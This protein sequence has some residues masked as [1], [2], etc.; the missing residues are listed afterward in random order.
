M[1]RGYFETIPLDIEEAA[2]IDGSSRIGNFTRIAFPL[3]KAGLVAVLIFTFIS[4]WQDFVLAR[5]F[6]R[7]VNNLTLPLLAENFENSAVLDQSPYFELL[8]PYSI[9][10]ALPVVIF[11]I[12]RQKDIAAGAV[13]GSVK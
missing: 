1:M 7:D 6:L 13:A 9:L 8:A 12:F 5:T 11:F 4:S 10:V 3:A 2:T